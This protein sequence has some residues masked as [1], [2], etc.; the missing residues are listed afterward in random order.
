MSRRG[1]AG[2]SGTHGRPRAARTG[3]PG[4][5]GG[6][7]AGAGS[8]RIERWGT[9]TRVARRRGWGAGRGSARLVAVDGDDVAQD[10]AVHRPRRDRR[11]ASGQRGAGGGRRGTL[12]AVQAMAPL[13][14][15]AGVV[16]VSGAR[17]GA[18][19]RH[20][21]RQLVGEHEA[22]RGARGPN[23]CDHRPGEGPP[24]RDDVVRHGLDDAEIDVR[25]GGTARSRRRSRCSRRRADPRSSSVAR[26][27]RERGRARALR[28]GA[29]ARAVANV[30]VALG[31]SV[32]TVHEIRRV[33]V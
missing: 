17:R 33:A 14:P 12:G 21:G 9:S 2:S 25:A 13:A 18:H 8:A 30:K 3:P 11:D 26:D 5:G 22:G 29:H 20:A 4:S 32:P 15:T 24:G 16:H 1:R 23:W 19:E 28:G 6:G 27:V 10:G 31:A 7:G